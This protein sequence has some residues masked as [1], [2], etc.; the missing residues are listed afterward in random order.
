MAEKDVEMKDT[1]EVPAATTETPQAPKEKEAL[2]H[3]GVFLD[4]KYK[5]CSQSKHAC[6]L[7]GMTCDS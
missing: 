1:K 3:A 4:V 6:R 7:L 2:I 5:C